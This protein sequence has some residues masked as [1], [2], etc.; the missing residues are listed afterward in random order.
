MSC[1][2]DWELLHV[3]EGQHHVVLPLSFPVRWSWSFPRHLH[4]LWVRRWVGDSEREDVTLDAA[5][6]DRAGH[7]GR[8][9]FN[10]E[11]PFVLLR[12]FT[13]W[14]SEGVGRFPP[15]EECASAVLDPDVDA[16]ASRLHLHTLIL[17]SLQIV[18]LARK[19]IEDASVHEIGLR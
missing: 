11:V 1:R 18:V 13:R 17:E 15:G 14:R 16:A 9:C 12:E 7:F 3:Q 5:R 6:E 2:D 19:G 10:V 8:G 4:R